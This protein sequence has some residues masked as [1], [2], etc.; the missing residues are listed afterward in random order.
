MLLGLSSILAA[1][2]RQ[3][4]AITCSTGFD[5]IM[6]NTLFCSE[7]TFEPPPTKQKAAGLSEQQADEN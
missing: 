4:V 1:K 6:S 7:S 2:K 3:A 5:H